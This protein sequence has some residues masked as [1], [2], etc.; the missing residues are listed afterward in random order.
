MIGKLI[1][2]AAGAQVAKHSKNVG[3]V[4]GA[5]IGA[6]AVPFI[7]RLRIPALLALGAGAYAFKKLTDKDA[8]PARKKA[9]PSKVSKTNA[10]STPAT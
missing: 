5:A 10:A 1:G 2:A 4:G 6:L 8:K 3:G 7:S 9:S